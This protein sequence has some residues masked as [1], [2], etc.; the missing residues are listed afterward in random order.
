MSLKGSL[1]SQV[2]HTIKRIFALLLPTVHSV[3]ILCL[4]VMHTLRAGTLG[5]SEGQGA[6]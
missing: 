4:P 6:S 3:Y 2:P 1:D 5:R